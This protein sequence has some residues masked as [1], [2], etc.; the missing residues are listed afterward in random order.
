MNIFYSS[1]GF[2]D[3]ANSYYK[4]S[5]SSLKIDFPFTIYLY[6]ANLK[7]LYYGLPKHEYFSN[8]LYSLKIYKNYS[9]YD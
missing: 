5:F 6:F 3:A 2:V 9:N 4:F 8:G 7:N 1:I